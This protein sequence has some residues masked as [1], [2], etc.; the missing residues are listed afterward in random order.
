M[1]NK[2]ALIGSP[3]PLPTAAC[4]KGSEICPFI[5][6]EIIGLLIRVLMFFIRSSGNPRNLMVSKQKLWEIQSNALEKSSPIIASG[7]SFLQ[8]RVLKSK[9]VLLQFAMLEL[10]VYAF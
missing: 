3:C 7:V 2:K 8:D 6:R 9:I 4:W 1:Q 10:D 5:D